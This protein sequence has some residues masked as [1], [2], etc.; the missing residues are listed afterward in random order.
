MSEFEFG[1]FSQHTI[2]QRVIDGDLWFVGKLVPI[3]D[4]DIEPQ[5]IAINGTKGVHIVAVP[6]V[7]EGEMQD[8]SWMHVPD[9]EP[10][11]N[12]NMIPHDVR[13]VM[14]NLTKE[15]VTHQQDQKAEIEEVP[16][17]DLN[18][19]QEAEIRDFA[20]QLNELDEAAAHLAESYHREN[21]VFH[22]S[23]G[24]IIPSHDESR[25]ASESKLAA[26]QARSK[27][28]ERLIR[29]T[30]GGMAEEEAISRAQKILAEREAPKP[31][32]PSR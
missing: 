5:A 13:K 8:I 2:Y 3:G 10:V 24:E 21:A 18:A 30:E 11:Q 32:G 17:K 6:V 16:V 7:K 1:Q 25:K 12:L 15:I 19:G 29:E 28:S 9:F 27:G 31:D 22:E 14:L 4:H 26:V 23:M 20:K